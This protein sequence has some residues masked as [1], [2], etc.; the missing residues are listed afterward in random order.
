MI[1]GIPQ[2]DLGSSSLGSP[3]AMPSFPQPPQPRAELPAAP[4]PP[5]EE[6]HPSYEGIAAALMLGADDAGA[7][8]TGVTHNHPLPP[9]SHPPPPSRQQPLAPVVN[10][11]RSDS[12]ARRQQAQAARPPHPPPV[13]PPL[14][15]APSYSR[16]SSATDHYRQTQPFPRDVRLDAHGRPVDDG[17]DLYDDWDEDLDPERERQ[18]EEEIRRA[19]PPPPVTAP[20]RRN[21][22]GSSANHHLYIPQEPQP[23]HRDSFFGHT[24]PS[25]SASY[26][27][28]ELPA[29]LS[30]SRPPTPAKR[31]RG[32]TQSSII[33]GQSEE[34]SVYSERP[35][36][37]PPIP[38][39]SAPAPTLPHLVSNSTAQ[40][41]I[42]QRRKAGEA[43]SVSLDVHPPPPLS[44]SHSPATD[45]STISQ[46]SQRALPSLPNNLGVAGRHRAVSQPG[47][48]PSIIGLQ[49]GTSSSDHDHVPSVPPLPQSALPRKTSFTTAPS[50]NQESPAFS[51]PSL[52]TTSGTPPTPGTYFTPATSTGSNFANGGGVAL[53]P[54]PN[55]PLPPVPPIDTV[56]RPYH[57][58]S[59]LHTSIV[60]PTGGYI[61]RKLHVPH[62]VWTQ[63]GAKLT[64]LVEKGKCIAVVQQG[65]DDLSKASH[66]FLRAPPQINPA[67]AR[68]VGDRWVRAL[69]EWIGVC[70]GIIVNMGKKLGMNEGM[71]AKKNTGWTK[72]TRTFEKMTNAKK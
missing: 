51:L 53:P 24:Q 43:G 22:S 21:T 40:G 30:S 19:Y 62:D 29:P 56:R 55:S 46:A 49:H 57:L 39:V 52:I 28:E 14:P 38:A 42:S 17:V 37:P 68:A 47:R 23:D 64:N 9:R 35:I 31:P 70:D 58:M 8:S 69:D 25:N 12:S 36:T 54:V 33:S 11:P 18:E 48:R 45:A 67:F 50:R 65:L 2:P 63:G 7:P 3:T 32:N 41:T 66:E 15:A 34:S 1:Y 59:L 10:R 71:T 27:V 61:T 44:R 13:A 4:R 16:P 26:V 60:T 6:V 20:R 72:V 5:S